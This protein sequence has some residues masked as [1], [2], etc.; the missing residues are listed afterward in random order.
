MGRQ[1]RI[2]TDDWLTFISSSRTRRGVNSIPSRCKQSSLIVP[3]A[4]GANLLIHVPDTT[5]RVDGGATSDQ[6]DVPR[7][8]T[9]KVASSWKN[10]LRHEALQ[11]RRDPTAA[12]PTTSLPPVPYRHPPGAP[13]IIPRS[14][15]Q[16]NPP[17]RRCHIYGARVYGVGEAGTAEWC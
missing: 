13:R 6:G 11:H 16:S 4:A 3:A 7:R 2:M 10:T 14:C 5:S 8:R 17:R 12:H 15:H 9:S 1:F